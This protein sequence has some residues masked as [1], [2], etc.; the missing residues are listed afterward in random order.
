MQ[1]QGLSGA[2]ALFRLEKYGPNEIADKGEKS[3]VVILGSQF[4]SPVVALLVIASLIAFSIG[5][6]VDAYLI[7]VIVVLNGVL[8]FVQEFKAEEAVK[9]LR[10]MGMGQV[11][12]RREGKD[13]EVETFKIVPGDLVY[14]EEGRR[15]PADGKVIE[16]IGLEVDEAALTGE[17]LPVTKKPDGESE[18]G[19]VFMGTLTARGRGWMVV[20]NTGMGTRFGQLARQLA[21]VEKEKSPLNKKLGE[22]TKWMA[23]VGVVSGV[24]VFFNSGLLTGVSLAVA[25]IPEGLP[26]VMSVTLG[27]GILKMARQKAIVRKM[28]AVEALGATNVI[29]TDK[30][31]TITK[32]QM[33]VVEIIGMVDKVDVIRAG[34]MCST[35][36]LVEKEP[37]QMV[38]I[39]DQT[40]GAILKL[41]RKMGLDVDEIRKNTIIEEEFL[42]DSDIKLG[43]VVVREKGKP[44]LMVFVMGAPEEVWSRCRI[45]NA[46][47]SRLKQEFLRLGTKGFRVV[48]IA[49]RKLERKLIKRGD[50]ETALEWLGLVAIADPV[51]DEAQ[52]VIKVAQ[53]AGI[54]VILATGDSEVTAK[55][56]ANKIGLLHS[57]EEIMSGKVVDQISDEQLRTEVEKVRIFS[58]VR[59]EHKLRIVKAL[60]SRGWVVTMTGDGVNDALAIKQADVGVAMGRVGTDVARETADVVL[61]DDNLATLVGAIENGRRILA[62]IMRTIRYLLACNF[63][64]VATILLVVGTGIG[65]GSPLLPVQLLWINLVTDGLPSLALAVDRTGEAMMTT[66]HKPANVFEGNEAVKLAVVVGLMATVGLFSFGLWGRAGVF[67]ALV[68]V[69]ILYAFGVRGWRKPTWELVLATG[70]ALGLQIV[71]LVNPTLRELFKLQ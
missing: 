54:R 49:R 4:T 23:V 61:T 69:Q 12:V 19:I 43:S 5:E 66:G 63:G 40:E 31:G 2:E 51:R 27:V 20:E 70:L 35:A 52:A 8:G 1:L 60:Q 26:A 13:F 36:E 11:R 48:G 57:G 55:T 59:P 67:T 53:Q 39:G 14:L 64:E 7:L 32:N 38:V 21:G 47:L 68:V 22:I 56:I 42:F 46:D 28:A 45:I 17:S 15:V 65:V 50:I 41:A 71:I 34:V 62:N 9:K 16:S 37:G 25:V 6:K 29:V 44:G 3:K 18:T 30:T 24:I 10:K 58:R 33:E